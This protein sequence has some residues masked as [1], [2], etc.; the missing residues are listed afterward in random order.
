MAFF[1]WPT[2]GACRPTPRA[3]RTPPGSTPAATSPARGAPSW[4]DTSGWST[5]PPRRRAARPSP[6]RSW[7]R[8]PRPPPRRTSG[9]TSSGGGS[10]WSATRTPG[11]D[12]VVEE[13]EGGFV[14]RYRNPAGA[15]TAALAVNR[16][17]DLASM[18]AEVAGAAPAASRGDRRG[19]GGLSGR[20]RRRP[21]GRPEHPPRGQR[22][23][24]AGGE[25][26][27][28]EGPRAGAVAPGHETVGGGG[29]EHQ[30]R[31]VVQAPPGPHP[32]PPAKA[33]RQVDQ[34][35]QLGTEDA[36]RNPQRTVRRGPRDQQRDHRDRH[37]TCP[38]R[39]TRRAAPRPSAR[40]ATGIGAG[41]RLP[42]GSAT[43]RAATW[44]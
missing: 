36:E 1:R 7:V 3:R 13:R 32:D 9:R 28:R 22:D 18:R 23:H 6:A 5:G 37:A 11:A 43:G 41:Q 24:R 17:S 20:R 30:V 19:L 21:A 26:V 33:E 10:R 14:A 2:T 38:A 35:H 40:A 25:D 31:R 12:A 4:G 8:H 29:A 42:P 34:E 16:P 39:G 44:P 27:H 15:V